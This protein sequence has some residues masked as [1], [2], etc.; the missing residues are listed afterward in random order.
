MNLD[1]NFVRSQFP[2][3][4]D[5]YVFFDNAGGS[6]IAKQAIDRINEYLMTSYVQHGA[7]YSV[8]EV[9]TSRVLEA[10]TSIRILINAKDVSEVVMGSSTTMLLRQLSQAMLKNLNKD[11]EIIVTDCDH[12]ANIG[13][14]RLLEAH[15]VIV[16][17]WKLNQESLTLDLDD[18]DRLM[19]EKT[20][21]VAL[22]HTS[23]ILGTINPIKEVAT[24]VHER[25]AL[26]CVDGV[27][28][29]PHRL[30]DVQELDVD[31]YLFSFY[32]TFGP[33]HAVL[34]GKQDL[35][36]NLDNI[37]HFFIANDAIPHKLQPG[38]PNHEL[39]YGVSG[40]MDYLLAFADHHNCKE[41][42]V[43]RSLANVYEL[44]ASYEESLNQ[45]L[46]EYLNQKDKV[47][48]IGSNSYSKEIRVPTISF[49]VKGRNSREITLK[50]DKYNIGIRYGDFYARQ[51]I[52]TLD[53]Q[54]YEGPVRVSMVHYNTI[55]EV[56]KLI[57]IFEESF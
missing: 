56:D 9:A 40:I 44:I 18:L 6:Q 27:A 55:E 25:G 38:G 36:L 2:G 57:Q 26:I 52:E 50:I 32:K 17:T 48:I 10:Q 12:E 43:R 45:R 53:L 20:V 13:C 11:D 24:F 5:D 39:S 35:L 30:V 51:L 14:W 21:L 47:R 1:I 37:N 29:T 3:L 54:K 31:Y 4:R 15:G 8:S 41:A 46:I 7:S 16:K 33:H 49:M 22:T 19:S 28:Y 23:N 42:N 34:Y